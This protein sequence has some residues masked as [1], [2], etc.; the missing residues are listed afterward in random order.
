MSTHAGVHYSFAERAKLSSH[1]LAKRLFSLM[2][3]KQSN[4]SVACDVTSVKELLKVAKDVGPH[5]AIL[6]TH[7]DILDDFSIEAMVEL[8]G[9]AKEY[10]F[11]LFEDRKFADI[12]NTVFHQYARGMYRISQWADVINAHILPG[13]GIIEGLAQE[14]EKR[15][16]GLLLLAQMSSE[17]AYTSANYIQYVESLASHY[18]E[19]VMGFIAQERLFPNPEWIWMTPGVSIKQKN[20]NLKQQYR[21]PQAAICEQGND[22]IIVGREIVMST[23]PGDKAYVYKQVA[24]EAHQSRL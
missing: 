13:P 22:I 9:L 21:S 8:K 19:F 7:V 10:E 12:G 14:G 23:R 17:G 2:Q 5:I 15:G 24:W 16:R 11:L 20:D 6:K 1:P 3:K 4:L 18:P